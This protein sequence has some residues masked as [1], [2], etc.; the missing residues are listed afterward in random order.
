M[1]TVIIISCF[2]FFA[3]RFPDDHS[4]HSK[5]D[6]EWV[7]FVGHLESEAGETIG[8]E[9]SFFRSKINNTEYFPVHFAISLPNRNKH[10]LSQFNATDTG[11][12][13]Y[14]DAQLIRSGDF[15]CMILKDGSFEIKANPRSDSF[16]LNLKLTPNSLPLIHGERGIS[17]KS[18][19]HKDVFSN[20]YSI[21]RLFSKGTLKLENEIITINSGNS[22]MDHEWSGDSKKPSLIST[23]N[24]S[25]DWMC[26]MFDD[27]SDLVV[28]NYKHSSKDPIETFGTYRNAKGQVWNFENEGDVKF[29]ESGKRWKSSKTDK[30]YPLSWVIEI[31]FLNMK[32]QSKPM[33]E[34]QEMDT[35][36]T[37]LNIYWEGMIEVQNLN[38]NNKTFG[39]GYLELKGR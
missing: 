2:L 27:G 5:S 6:L 35:R 39:K 24:N 15:E 10:F 7:Y 21:P 19:I 29:I 38:Q 25:W 17:K 3:F 33:M 1:R 32:I 36:K 37:T 11:R 14:F 8:Y 30:L 20:Y 26:V 23:S 18:R 13:G 16:S 28:F 34:D 22:W 12:I 31:P 9:L 4:F